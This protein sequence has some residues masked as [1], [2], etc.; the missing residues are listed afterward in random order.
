MGTNTAADTYWHIQYHPAYV[1]GLK[2]F[3]T[4]NLNKS[5]TEFNDECIDRIELYSWIDAATEQDTEVKIV[6]RKTMRNPT[7]P[8][9]KTTI[10]KSDE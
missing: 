2:N 8:K 3:Y 1:P 9:K 4:D 7:K 6:K 10:N 5:K